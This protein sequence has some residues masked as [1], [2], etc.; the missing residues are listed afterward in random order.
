VEVRPLVQM[1]G[2]AH[3][4]EVFLSDAVVLDGDRI[5][6]VDDGWKVAVSLLAH[7][8]AGADRTA[9]TG[10]GSLPIWLTALSDEGRLTGSVMRD[11]AMRLYCLDEAIRL[12]QLRSM[13]NAQAGRRS[14]PEGSG[15]KLN[16]ARSFKA[17]VELAAAATGAHA[18]LSNWDS[19]VDLLTAPSMS[20]R[21]GTDEIQRNILGERVLG[22]PPE[23]RTDRDVPWSLSRRGLTAEPS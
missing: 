16:G 5:G 8:R 19:S 9:P 22:L 17:R 23:P 3:F 12:S 21:G 4:S 10:R 11:R 13:A 14:G 2:D 7:E 20:I 15:M 18:M 6:G 1:N